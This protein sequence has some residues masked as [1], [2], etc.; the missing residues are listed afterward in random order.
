MRS[1]VRAGR[2]VFYFI[3]LNRVAFCFAYIRVQFGTGA[4]AVIEILPSFI[5]FPGKSGIFGSMLSTDTENLWHR[6][7]TLGEVARIQAGYL[8]R[9]R[10]EASATGTHG[11]I[12]ARDISPEQ[13]LS[14]DGIVRFVP[15]R[16]PGLYR[17]SRGDILLVA[18]GYPHSV[19]LI[20][21]DLKDTLASSIFHIL[22]PRSER[23]LPA[24]LA[25]WLSQ[26]SVQ[27]EINANA[28]GTGISYLR[29]Q[30]VEGLRVPVPPFPLQHRI[31]QI[32]ALWD[33]RKTLQTAIDERRECLIQS[34][35]LTSATAGI[36][37]P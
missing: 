19:Y 7:R 20:T 34:A 10:V 2:S 11:L 35:C 24:Y 3:N 15:E 28:G 6:D 18:R 23:V 14:P 30:A 21:T 26:P 13:G 33:R 36:L 9:E 16:D 8:S 25:W 32:N 31:V 29:R 5:D 4:V 37:E 1:P 22:R 27:A 12:Q 17:V